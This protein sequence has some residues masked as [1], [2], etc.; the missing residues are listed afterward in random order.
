MLFMPSACVFVFDGLDRADGRAETR[1]PVA[2]FQKYQTI[3]DNSG[4]KQVALINWNSFHREP[5]VVLTPLP[6]HVLDTLGGDAGHGAPAAELSGP[7]KP[8]EAVDWS[9]LPTKMM[10]SLYDFQVEG[11]QYIVEH[12]G[13]GIIGDEMG[14]GKTVQAIGVAWYYKAEW[15]VLV[16]VPSSMRGAWREAF[17]EWIP[18][19]EDDD[20]TVVMKG[21]D[22]LDSLAVNIISYGWLV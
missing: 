19:L 9:R 5:N 8:V 15:P 6:K 1:P 21:K 11:I 2:T 20:V 10:R 13:R 3:R 22:P 17:V 12:G 18:A 4:R 16:I 14:L 7:S